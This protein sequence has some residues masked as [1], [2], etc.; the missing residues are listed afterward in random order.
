MNSLVKIAFFSR[1]AKLVK[2]PKK[3]PGALP[4]AA[5]DG[6]PG[7]LQESFDVGG[8]KIST[9]QAVFGG[10]AVGGLMTPGD[11]SEKVKGALLGAGIGGI[12]LRSMG[13][14]VKPEVAAAEAAPGA[15]AAA[16]IPGSNK[17]ST[18]FTGVKVTHPETGVFE[19]A[20]SRRLADKSDKL[21]DKAVREE[22]VRHRQRARS[23]LGA[24]NRE[25]IASAP[26]RRE[27]VA[28]RTRAIGRRLLGKDKP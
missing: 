20:R 14:K 25:E 10:A 7:V 28:L 21:L 23:G 2:V 4:S 15:V 9:R 3:G 17:A 11:S 27:R 1:A 19:G 18:T 24:M 16:G 26:T 12:G 8:S 6:K 5:A 13:K 22:N